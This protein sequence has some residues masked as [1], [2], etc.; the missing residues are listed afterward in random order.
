[1]L[2]AMVVNGVAAIGAGPVT[3]ACERN[4]GKHEEGGHDRFHAPTHKQDQEP[5]TPPPR[6]V[7]ATTEGRGGMPSLK[8][9]QR[10]EGLSKV[11]PLSSPG[12]WTARKKVWSSGVKIGPHTSAPV[13]A[14]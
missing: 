7:I 14:W 10:V 12:C 11:E 3:A 8:S 6:F 2:K 1:M 4:E 9:G 13:G 5:I